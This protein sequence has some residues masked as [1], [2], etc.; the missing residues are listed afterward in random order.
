MSKSTQP[1]QFYHRYHRRLET[2]KVEG[3]KALRWLYET[4]AGRLTLNTVAKRFWFSWLY[5]RL[6][7]RASTARLIADYCREYG[8]DMEEFQQPVEDFPHFAAFFER[9][10]KPTA[11]PIAPEEHELIF[12]ADGRHLLISNLDHNQKFYAKRSQWDLEA[13]LGDREEARYYQGGSMLISRLCPVDYHRFH[14]PCSGVP[15]GPKRIKGALYSVN[16]IALSRDLSYLWRNKREKM[17]LESDYGNRIT[18]V[19]IGATMV[20]KIEQ[21]YL[22]DQRVAK[23]DEKGYFAIG[24]SCIVTLFARGEVVWDEDLLEYGSQGIEVYARMGDRCGLLLRR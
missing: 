1:V 19:E 8:I 4:S 16:P 10:L 20:G 23:G 2:E 18:I 21:T 5:G 17:V 11:R 6:K 9:K 14:F 12:P 3:E 13:F 15:S 7:R 24:G 22:A